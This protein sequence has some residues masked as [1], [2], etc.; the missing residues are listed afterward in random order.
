MQLRS[1]SSV[2]VSNSSLFLTSLG[3]LFRRGRPNPSKAHRR[4]QRKQKRR[5]RKAERASDASPG[6]AAAPELDQKAVRQS[7]NK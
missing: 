1:H 2:L 4:Q 7:G 6:D 3:V 5:L